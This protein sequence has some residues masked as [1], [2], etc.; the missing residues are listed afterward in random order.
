MIPKHLLCPAQIQRH[1]HIWERE[2]L[3]PLG[4]RAACNRNKDM[5]R[6]L[7]NK[8]WN[9]EIWAAHEGAAGSREIIPGRGQWELH[10]DLPFTQRGNS[11]RKLIC[12]LS[13]SCH[14]PRLQIVSLLYW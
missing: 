10:H 6:N 12:I 11:A 3:L 9:R 4:S 13:L 7:G 2:R 8:G 1:K 14:K 5:G